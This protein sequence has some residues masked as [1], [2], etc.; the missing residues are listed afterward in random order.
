MST[1]S[2]IRIGI[3]EDHQILIDGLKS[4]LE[5]EEH[6]TVPLTAVNGRLFI[7]G[8]EKQPVDVVLMDINMPELSGIEA[9]KQIK[10]KFPDI[11]VLF[12][13]M[14]N[15]LRV[16]KALLKVGADGY[17]IKDIDIKEIK[18]AIEKVYNG[19]SYFSKSVADNILNAQLKKK[20]PTG[21]ELGTAALPITITPRENE[22]LHYICMEYTS[23]EIAGEL[24]ISFNT[25][26][27][28]RKKLLNKLNCKNSVG[29]VKYAM[30]NGLV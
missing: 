8:L 13:S 12:L 28:H 2:L 1:P 7:E 21:R 9:T 3:A 15:D 24:Y 6:L 14:H 19:E 20:I 18:L 5:E 25:V 4:L 10:A 23:A 26:E 16:L 11:K 30:E 22:V 27:T 29:L 17:L